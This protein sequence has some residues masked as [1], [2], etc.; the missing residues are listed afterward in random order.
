MESY[1]ISS[2]RSTVRG[3]L[4]GNSW[5]KEI[6][7]K[8][9][10]LKW[11]GLKI[12]NDNVVNLFSKAEKASDSSKNAMRAIIL[13]AAIHNILIHKIPL[14]HLGWAANVLPEEICR[15]LLT[16]KKN[17]S[18]LEE[19]KI[20]LELVFA[21]NPQ[22]VEMYAD[23]M[24][25]HKQES[26]NPLIKET[27]EYVSYKL[28]EFINLNINDTTATTI[29]KNHG[30]QNRIINRL[31]YIPN[32][33][34][35]HLLPV[36]EFLSNHHVFMSPD[37]FGEYITLL[38]KFAISNPDYQKFIRPAVL[39]ALDFIQQHHDEHE[40][41]TD[42][43][44]Q[45]L[46]PIKKMVINCFKLD[47][48]FLTEE[49]IYSLLEILIQYGVDLADSYPKFKIKQDLE[50]LVPDL[51]DEKAFLVPALTKLPEA[52]SVALL[53]HVKSPVLM[54]SGEL[55]L[56]INS[57]GHE[58]E[59]F[60]E[61]D[62]ITSYSI[63]QM[64]ELIADS[65]HNTVFYAFVQESRI[66]LRIWSSDTHFNLPYLLTLKKDPKTNIRLLMGENYLWGHKLYELLAGAT[67]K[68]SK[69]ILPEDKMEIENFLIK[70]L[71]RALNLLIWTDRN[72][73]KSE[74]S[75]EVPEFQQLMDKIFQIEA[76]LYI[77]KQGF[78]PVQELYRVLAERHNF[79]N[80]ELLQY[81]LGCSSLLHHKIAV[82]D[83]QDN[84]E[85]AIK[86]FMAINQENEDITRQMLGI[87]VTCRQVK[88]RCH[89]SQQCLRDI[90]KFC[91][92]RKDF[93]VYK[94]QFIPIAL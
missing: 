31:Q 76:I 18:A 61:D 32:E 71:V 69:L 70:D 34:L 54:Q 83:N 94:E 40:E 33:R 22:L 86:R 62:V 93:G 13:M 38:V 36:F 75:E 10:I 92:T 6:A 67:V 3:F 72:E 58:M 46:V 52:I 27:W 88:P 5:K 2:V 4:G 35:K 90:Y 41:I 89:L 16:L 20:A 24:F 49:N 51:E 77:S 66:N 42:Y 55:R 19:I 25:A 1:K 47:Y 81:M 43:C 78:Q 50:V 44:L 53:S 87:L 65:N 7:D 91:Q 15:K 48:K 60:F 29:A 85:I 21:K 26:H 45:L 30:Y 11:C 79:D 64:L 39:H 63:K 14:E 28:F 73:T 17:E 23:Y 68:H 37:R 59:I 82:N 74:Y 12:T 57:H 9:L 84:I 80:S 8:N 56:Q